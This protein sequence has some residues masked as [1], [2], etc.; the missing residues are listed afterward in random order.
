VRFARAGGAPL[1]ELDI[2]GR[3]NRPHRNANQRS[4]R[5]SS[6][7]ATSKAG[8]Y[9]YPLQSVLVT[10]VRQRLI[11]GLR[12]LREWIRP[13]GVEAQYRR[14]YD[15][16]ARTELSREEEALSES[17]LASL[18]GP[19]EGRVDHFLGLYSAE[20]GR[21]AL[22]RYGFLQLLRDKGF[23]NLL[24][25]VDTSDASHHMLRI[26]FDRRDAEHLLIEMVLGFRPLQL[27]DGTKGRM[28]SIEWLLMQDPRE[29]FP[30][31]RPRLPDQE[32]PGLGLFRWQG[33]LLRL[34]ATRLGCDG[35]MN[36][37]AQFHNAV[38]YG[39]V[40][41]FVDPVEEGRFRALERDLADLSLRD[42]SSAIA[43]GRVREV[44]GDT[45]QWQGRPQVLGITLPIQAYFERDQYR[46]TVERIRDST[47][48]LVAIG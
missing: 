43:M 2:V 5:P 13:T 9:R 18:L 34:M 8:C 30:S 40:M 41:K 15:G 25:S 11:R 12:D 35:M 38:L 23:E 26:H 28:L 45:L 47:R 4:G 17:D 29:A 20:G 14:V 33:E 44:D 22:E 19:P 48:F 31:D 1:F 46:S 32:Y 39:R 24:L 36:N 7:C 3:E 27:P 42:A 10:T 6:Q 21:M 16:L 37:P